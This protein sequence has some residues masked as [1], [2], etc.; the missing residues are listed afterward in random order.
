MATM[1]GTQHDFASATIS[2]L[3]LEYDALEAYTKAIDKLEN[4]DYKNKLRE[5]AGD[6]ERHIRQ[7]S[8]LLSMHKVDFAAGPDLKQWLTKGKVMLADLVGDRTILFAMFTNEIDTNKAYDSMLNRSDMWME[9]HEILTNA[10]EDEKK[11]K[12]WLEQHFRET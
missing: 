10:R 11:H 6:H 5:F 4:N 7:L 9:A 3:E 12:A 1:V 8:M 2:L